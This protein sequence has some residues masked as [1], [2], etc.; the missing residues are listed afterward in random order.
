LSPQFSIKSNPLL[1]SFSF[2]C[3]L[4]SLFWAFLLFHS[5]SLY[6]YSFFNVCVSY[7]KLTLFLWICVSRLKDRH[8]ALSLSLCASRSRKP[9]MLHFLMSFLDAI[10]CTLCAFPRKQCWCCCLRYM[11]LSRKT[12]STI[13]YVLC[14]HL[15]YVCLSKKTTLT[16]SSPNI[17]LLVICVCLCIVSCWHLSVNA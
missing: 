9:R 13:A 17:P 12:T 10:A 15:C 2:F 6:F 4:S 5:F 8:N 14:A 3:L 11:Y 1:A 7:R 16:P